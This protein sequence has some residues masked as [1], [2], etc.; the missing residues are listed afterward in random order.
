[1]TYSVLMNEEQ[2]VMLLMAMRYFNAEHPSKFGDEGT[3]MAVM[4]D[5]MPEIEKDD[6]GTTH[7]L[8]L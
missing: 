1:M 5:E 4:L 8:C 7:G 3:L 2:R 6:P